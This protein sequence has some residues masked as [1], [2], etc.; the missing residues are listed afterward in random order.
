[1]LRASGVKRQRDEAAADPADGVA[2]AESSAKRICVRGPR[3]GACPAKVRGADSYLAASRAAPVQSMRRHSD[4][5]RPQLIILCANPN[6]D[7]DCD[8]MKLIDQLYHCAKPNCAVDCD[9]TSDCT[10]APTR[11]AMRIA[12]E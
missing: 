3:S 1:M 6:C 12:I 10:T 7:E 9:R 5:L 11:I 8:R 4:A 2:A